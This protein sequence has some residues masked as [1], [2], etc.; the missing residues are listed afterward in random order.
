MKRFVLSLAVACLCAVLGFGQTPKV[1][2]FSMLVADYDYTCQTTDKDGKDK[3]EGY[4]VVL[5]AGKDMACTQGQLKHNGERDFSEQVLYVPTTWQNYPKGK[6]TSLEVIPLDRY[7]TSEKMSSPKWK[8]VAERDTI[9][10]YPCQ[11][12]V[13]EY[14]GRT[15]NVWFAESLPTKFGPW[16]LHGTPGLILRAVSDD[17]IHKFECKSVD[18][19]KEEITQEIPVGVVKCSR[20]QFV[21]RRNKLFSDPQ[22]VAKGAFYYIPTSS[23]KSMTV[24]NGTPAVND[25][26]VNTKPNK[27]Q[28]LDY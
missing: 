8:I 24:F 11:K 3:T 7:L 14:G 1:L 23:I 20:K 25:V 21:D 2:G 6:M 12:A 4:G 28:P 16:H 27:F 18:N 5:Q 9:C 22:Y 26:I 13:G 17:G 10:G 15:W 19:K